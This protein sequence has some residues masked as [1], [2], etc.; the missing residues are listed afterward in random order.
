V[1]GGLAVMAVIFLRA[2]LGETPQW[3]AIATALGGF[4]TYS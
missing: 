2:P 1:V 3:Q 4:A